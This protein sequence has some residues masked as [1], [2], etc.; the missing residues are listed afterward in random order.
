MLL[1]GE[2]NSPRVYLPAPRGDPAFGSAPCSRPAPSLPDI[3]GAPGSAGAR[4]VPPWDQPLLQGDQ[5]EPRGG[6]Q[7]PALHLLP[8]G[9]Q[10]PLFRSCGDLESPLKVPPSVSAWSGGVCCRVGPPPA[11]PPPPPCALFWIVYIAVFR[12][13]IVSSIS[14][15]LL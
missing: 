13:T 1:T 15:N 2:C 5:G 3:T 6:G 7:V 9:F 14:S 8:C 10:W 12:V 4:P 11:P